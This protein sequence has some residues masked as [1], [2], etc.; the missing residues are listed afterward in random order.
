MAALLG[1]TEEEVAV[2]AERQQ[3]ENVDLFWSVAP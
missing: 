3:A 2:E 1:V